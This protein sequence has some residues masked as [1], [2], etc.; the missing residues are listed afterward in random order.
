MITIPSCKVYSHCNIFSGYRP[1][2]DCWS[3]KT[4]FVIDHPPTLVLLPT[5]GKH[6]PQHQLVQ[7]GYG[8]HMLQVH[9]AICTHSI[10]KEVDH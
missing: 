8:G 5:A 7:L 6:L 2:N 9:N 4:C 3:C 10:V 1:D